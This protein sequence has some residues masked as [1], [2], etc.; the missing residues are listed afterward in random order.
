MERKEHEGANRAKEEERK[1]E[2]RKIGTRAK[3]GQ[4]QK[5]RRCE[6]GKTT[7]AKIRQ[8]Q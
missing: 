6:K 3:Q 8:N 5:A 2:D 4:E 1:K 7:R